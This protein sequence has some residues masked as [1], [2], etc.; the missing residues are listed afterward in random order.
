MSLRPAVIAVMSILLI[1]L[2]TDSA[3]AKPPS[4]TL[5][6]GTMP[7]MAGF[8]ITLDGQ[9]VSDRRLWRRAFQNDERLHHQ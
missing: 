3:A 6:I 2:G 4:Q 9:T 8:P 1:L 5:E 7:A